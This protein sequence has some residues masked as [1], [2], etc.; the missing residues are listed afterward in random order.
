MTNYLWLV[1]FSVMLA[2]GQMFFKVVA[3][4]MQGLPLGEGMLAI[5]G[6]PMLYFALALYGAATLLWIWILSRV[7]LSQAYPW[8]AVA[9]A[10]VPILAGAVFHERVSPAYWLGIALVML[11]VY[12]TQY[13]SQSN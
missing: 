3:R 1:T 9:M 2:V 6:M 13:A 5:V 11:G 12:V 7:P 4:S 10:T 8:V